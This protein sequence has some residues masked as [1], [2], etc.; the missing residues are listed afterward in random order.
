MTTTTGTKTD[1]QL[2]LEVL[3]ALEWEPSVNEAHIGVSV[4]NGVVTLSGHVP[5]FAEK[6]DAETAAKRVHGVRAVADEIDV[7]LPGSSERTDPEIALACVTA[8][9][10]DVFVPKEKIQVTVNQG[11]VELEGDVEWHYQRSA[12]ERVTRNLVGVRNVGN[13]ILVKPRLTPSEL[14]TKI[15]RAFLRTAE[16]DAQGIEVE[17]NGGNV[18]LRGSVRTTT[19]RDEATRV[20]WS[21]PGVVTVENRITV[22]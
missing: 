22:R 17:A 5:S 4:T 16:L 11:W 7:R 1:H 3:E 19:D 8:L 18:L 20:A 6:Y 14:K 10:K 21:A 9:E 13:R 15:E 12:A 2:Q